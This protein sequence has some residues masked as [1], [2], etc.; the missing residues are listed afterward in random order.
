MWPERYLVGEGSEG[1]ILLGA[2][3]VEDAV[4]LVE[5]VE[6][7]LG[8]RR[9]RKGME[10]RRKVGNWK[11]VDVSREVKNDMAGW[12]WSGFLGSLRSAKTLKT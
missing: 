11:L 2:V 8:L 10:G 1:R 5:A 6:S 3:D 7:V 9:R 12:Y 4:E